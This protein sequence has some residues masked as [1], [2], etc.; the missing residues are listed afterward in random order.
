MKMI[1]KSV[2]EEAIYQQFAGSIFPKESVR[3]PMPNRRDENPS[4]GFFVKRGKWQWKDNATGEGG[5][6]F[7]FVATLE[8]T[9]IDGAVNIIAKTF[10]ID[11][12]NTADII[13]NLPGHDNSL[14]QQRR[15]SLIQAERKNYTQAELNLWKSFNLN[16]AM[17]DFL[18]IRSASCVWLQKH[19]WP[20]PRKIWI[21]TPEDP[22][23]YWVSPYSNH[24]KCYRPLHPDKRF[25]WLSNMDDATDIQGYQQA[26]IK[27]CPGRPLILSKSMKEIGFFQTFGFNSMAQNAEG[28]IIDADFIRHIKTYCY[29]ILAIY[30]ADEAGFKGMRRLWEKYQIPGLFIP[31]Y[32]PKR[33]AKDPTDLWRADHTKAYK[34]INLT[35]EYIEHIRRCGVDA[36]PF[37]FRYS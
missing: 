37:G 6:C 5:D 3:S 17:L 34:L 23:F 7:D 11:G 24:I 31:K 2:S 35:N 1:L 19:D 18:K 12:Y 27:Q 28:Y 15:R 13:R 25:K 4:F 8:S 9:D 10:N 36:H 22:I 21:S 26:R 30:D 20:E 32:A 29:P 14:K 16:P 33:I